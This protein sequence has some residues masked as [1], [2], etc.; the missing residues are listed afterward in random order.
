MIAINSVWSPTMKGKHVHSSSFIWRAH[1]CVRE[2]GC[3]FYLCL[4]LSQLL[5]YEPWRINTVANKMRIFQWQGEYID[6]DCCDF[7][8]WSAVFLHSLELTRKGG[9]IERKAIGSSVHLT[10][11]KFKHFIGAVASMF[12]APWADTFIHS[13]DTFFS[14]CTQDL[15]ALRVFY[16][17]CCCFACEQVENENIKN[18]CKFKH[19]IGDAVSMF[20]APWVAQYI[21][22]DLVFAC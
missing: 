7:N 21:A 6:R 9:I 12:C 5:I 22:C 15:I 11:W 1:A 14:R 3:R 16:G 17:L 19:L 13:R 4:S 20:C 8:A 10:L 2:Q 18:S